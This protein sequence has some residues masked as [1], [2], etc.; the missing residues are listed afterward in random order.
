MLYISFY[1]HICLSDRSNNVTVYGR[2]IK[3]YSNN[4]NFEKQEKIL[5][6]THDTFQFKDDSEGIDSFIEPGILQDY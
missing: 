3:R 6:M 5:G 2:S 1:P 4:C